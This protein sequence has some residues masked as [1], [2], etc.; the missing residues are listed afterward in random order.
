M[1]QLIA[2]FALWAL[3]RPDVLQC[4]VRIDSAGSRPAGSVIYVTVTGSETQLACAQRVMDAAWRHPSFQ[5]LR[6][7]KPRRDINREVAVAGLPARGGHRQPTLP[8][9][10][11]LLT[12]SATSS[13]RD[14]NPFQLRHR[15]AGN[16]LRQSLQSHVVGL[17]W[18]SIAIT[19]RWHLTR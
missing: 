7:G 1:T 12:T 3:A 4:R 11:T 5:G 18:S 19:S 15:S 9:V 13:E 10:A 17:W 16:F 6:T 14:R 8:Q 2:S